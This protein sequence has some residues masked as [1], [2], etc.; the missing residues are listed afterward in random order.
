MS[1]RIMFQLYK[2]EVHVFQTEL[3]TF[4]A[5]ILFFSLDLS[6][7]T[8]SSVNNIDSGGLLPRPLARTSMVI[9]RPKRRGLGAEA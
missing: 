1:R 8:R 4:L 2:R 6:Q 7:N 5:V 9:I 3:S